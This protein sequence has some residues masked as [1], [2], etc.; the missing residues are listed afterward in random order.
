M[1]IGNLQLT[2]EDFPEVALTVGLGTPEGK[3]ERDGEQPLLE[4]LDRRCFTRLQLPLR[5]VASLCPRLLWEMGE[6]GPCPLP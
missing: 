3:E 1:S 2:Q 5:G 4:G 6:L